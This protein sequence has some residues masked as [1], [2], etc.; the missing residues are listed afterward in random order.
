MQRNVMKTIQ[1]YV[2]PLPEGG[3]GCCQVAVVVDDVE[4]HVLPRGAGV[5]LIEHL[6]AQ[7]EVSGTVT[8]DPEGPPVIQVRAYQVIDPDDER[9]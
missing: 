3:K 9:W 2:A 4:Y 8:E 1:G 5:D 7:V 6:S